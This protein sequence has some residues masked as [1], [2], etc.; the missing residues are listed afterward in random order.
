MK[1]IFLTMLFAVFMN[2]GFSKEGITGHYRIVSDIWDQKIPAG[3]C[4]LQGVVKMKQDEAVIEN[5]EVGLLEGYIQTR[6]DKAGK[7]SLLCD[8]GEQMP[9]YFFKGDLE[10]IIINDYEFKSQHRITLEVYLV[11]AEPRTIKRKP[12]IYCYAEKEITASV[13]LDPKGIFTFTYPA[14]NEGWN[15]RVNQN[16]GV[17]DLSS[18]KNYPYLF[19]EA[20][21]NFLFYRTEQN[22]IPGFIINTDSTIQFLEN[23][24]TA[25]GI[26]QT[27]QTDFITFWGPILQQKQYAFIQFLVDDAYESD[28]ASLTISP[29]PNAMRRVYMLCSPMDQ[30]HLEMPVIPQSFETFERFGFTVVEW[31]G[32]DLELPT[33]KPN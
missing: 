5:V 27:E 26:N 22:A 20:K 15:V 24:L 6:T 19:W 11:P 3:K 23:H 9:P 14:Y 13:T 28:I 8:V 30:D 18:G 12:V 1:L 32:S 16:G 31:G 21:S 2:T 10:E 7:F 17:T 33:I 29:K 4:E 25:M